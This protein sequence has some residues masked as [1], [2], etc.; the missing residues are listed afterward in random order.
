MTT[1]K[2]IRFIVIA[3]V[4]SVSAVFFGLLWSGWIDYWRWGVEIYS[5][6]KYFTS[7][8]HIWENEITFT[9]SVGDK[10]KI[11][12]FE[13]FTIKVTNVHLEMESGMVAEEAPLEISFQ[14]ISHDLAFDHAIIYD[15]NILAGLTRIQTEQYGTFVDFKWRGEMGG[16]KNIKWYSY[17]VANNG[18]YNQFSS[19]DITISRLVYTEYLR[20]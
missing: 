17:S 6:E 19:I 14:I 8:E 11:I 1:K 7:S 3:L 2:K 4:V 13:G 9:V 15:V 20:K 18:C 5:K 16:P 10:N 12:D